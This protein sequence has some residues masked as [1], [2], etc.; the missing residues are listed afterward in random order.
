M[1]M[2]ACMKLV[3][4]C[5]VKCEFINERNQIYFWDEIFS[6]GATTADGVVSA[7]LGVA[8]GGTVV[9][10]VDAVCGKSSI[11]NCSKSSSD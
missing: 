1:Y 8:V 9:G 3:C 11:I 7:G 4:V 2:C 6:V 10:G 5:V